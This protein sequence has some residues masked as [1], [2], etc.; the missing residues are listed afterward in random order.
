MARVGG[1]CVRWRVVRGGIG[2]I[3]RSGGGCVGIWVGLP[4]HL[5]LGHDLM[6][7]KVHFIL[8]FDMSRLERLA[9]LFASCD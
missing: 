3:E 4:A 9:R 2:G 1:R 8:Y 6:S 5:G 7:P